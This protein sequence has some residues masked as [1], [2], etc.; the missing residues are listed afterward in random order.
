MSRL[1]AAIVVCAATLVGASSANATTISF[2]DGTFALA[3]YSITSYKSSPLVNVTVTEC[4]SCGDP[5]TA[6]DFV[7]ND[8]G[9]AGETTANAVINN[10]F[11]YDPLLS[12][13]ISSRGID[14]SVDKYL[15]FAG[16]TNV[17]RP[18]IEQDGQFYLAAIVG[19]S[20]QTG[21]DLFSGT[22][23]NA[24]DFV[25]FDFTT[26]AFGTTN[27]NFAGDPMSFGLTQ[28]FT[29]F[30]GTAEARY[31]NLNIT[32]N[33]VPEPTSLLL[34]GSGLIGAVVRRR[35]SRSR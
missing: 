26:G 29:L 2:T 30:G 13:P 32:V 8:S 24:T 22:A 27:P 15:I 20:D 21:Y 6:L 28:F 4:A 10:S 25:S 3:D 33:P 14:A 19:P 35:R 11:T 18:T 1:F 31:D 34:L 9:S 17:F 16:A 7:V 5:G 23:L 12:G